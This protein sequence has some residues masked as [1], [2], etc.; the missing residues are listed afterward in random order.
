MGPGVDVA[1]YE[2][3]RGDAGKIG[4]ELCATRKVTDVAAMPRARQVGITGHSISPRLYI[5]IPMLRPSTGPDRPKF[6][7]STPDSR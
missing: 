5:A 3:L 6:S 1:D 4:A 7:C 2:R